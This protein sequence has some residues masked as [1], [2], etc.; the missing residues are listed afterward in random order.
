MIKFTY[1]YLLYT[2]YVFYFFI[3]LGIWTETTYLSVILDA[4]RLFISFFLVV[5]FNPFRKT[6]F[7]SFDKKIAFHGGLILFSI[8]TLDSII[9][10][11]PFIGSDLQNRLKLIQSARS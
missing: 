4:I 8:T 6:E 1:T 9:E 7:N 3:L 11:L 5:R 2:T 10:N